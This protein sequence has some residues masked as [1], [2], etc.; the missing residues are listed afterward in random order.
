MLLWLSLRNTVP[1]YSTDVN[2]CNFLVS[3]RK[4]QCQHWRTIDWLWDLFH[5][6]MDINMTILW[7]L[8]LV[9]YCWVLRHNDFVALV[10]V[11]PLDKILDEYFDMLNTGK[12][13]NGKAGIFW[14]HLRKS[15]IRS[16][17]KGTK[18]HSAF[19]PL[20]HS[21]PTKPRTWCRPL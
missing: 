1:G 17:C 16:E 7:I 3:S 4:I 18:Q 8:C 20:I 10:K 15:C 6:S 12:L 14:T 2:T 19:C 11:G 5:H 21:H 9:D 13:V